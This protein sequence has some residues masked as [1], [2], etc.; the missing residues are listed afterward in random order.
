LERKIIK[1]KEYFDIIE[2]LNE[3]Y[4]DNNYFI[5]EEI[6]DFDEE[7]LEEDVKETESLPNIG[8][9]IIS[10]HNKEGD[11]ISHFHVDSVDKKFHSAV[12]LDACDYFLHKPYHVMFRNKK[13][14]KVLQD[15]LFN[16]KDK[17]NKILWKKMVDFW[18]SA[19]DEKFHVNLKKEDIPDYRLLPTKSK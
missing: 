8:K 7:L 12:K 9:C 14:T 18:N 13:Q 2:V 11:N 3:R 19:H 4:G 10:L 15:V 1:P 5:Y 6:I 17:D 16:K